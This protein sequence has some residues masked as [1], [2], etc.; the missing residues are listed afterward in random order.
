MV[1]MHGG[2]VWW[3]C[4][5]ERAGEARIRARQGWARLC[6]AVQGCAR[7]GEAVQ[8]WARHVRMGQCSTAMIH[9]ALGNA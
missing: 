7:L 6:K 2:D 1:V 5:I 4:G 3:R 9:C 8:G